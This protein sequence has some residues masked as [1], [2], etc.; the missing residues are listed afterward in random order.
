MTPTS[1]D[2]TADLV[3]PARNEAEN[4]PALFDALAPLVRPGK[5]LRRVVLADN[6]STDATA[7][8]AAERGAVVVHEPRPGYGRACLAALARIRHDPDPPDAIAFLDADLADDPARLPALLAPLADGS[9]DLVLG[10]RQR[11]AEPG[12]LDP[13]QRFGNRVICSMYLKWRAIWIR[14]SI[15]VLVAIIL[16]SLRKK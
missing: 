15:P 10:Q 5:P 12:A 7:R 2:F 4:V 14:W 13:H 1:A 3:I 8:L 11:L 6:G 9:A 16:S